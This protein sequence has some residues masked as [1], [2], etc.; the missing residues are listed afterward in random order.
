M[1]AR[2][3]WCSTFN[4]QSHQ[5]TLY[6]VQYSNISLFSVLAKEDR[7]LSSPTPPEMEFLS[8]HILLFLLAEFSDIY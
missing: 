6:H 2:V 1:R 3:E 5:H 4:K 7:K 8:S